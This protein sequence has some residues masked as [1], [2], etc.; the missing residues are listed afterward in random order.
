M[1]QLQ[2]EMMAAVCDFSYFNDRQSFT[3]AKPWVSLAVDRSR[4][5]VQLH[6]TSW[7]RLAV[8]SP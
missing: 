6:I 2:E 4:C 3:N 7:Q 1:S 8:C 5:V